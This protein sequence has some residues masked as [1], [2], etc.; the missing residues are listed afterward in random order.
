MGSKNLRLFLQQLRL[1]IYVM[2]GSRF[3]ARSIAIAKSA[4]S[5]N[6]VLESFMAGQSLV[7]PLLHRTSY[8]VMQCKTW[9]LELG[10][11]TLERFPILNYTW[12]KV[13]DK[14][15]ELIGQ[16]G[17]HRDTNYPPGGLLSSS[18]PQMSLSHSLILQ[19]LPWTPS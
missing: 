9:Q 1:H 6:L 2:M 7:F 18:H 15:I 3:E 13:G 5:K 12:I 4:S 8:S 10:L 17:H 11:P 16:F 14:Y 19:N